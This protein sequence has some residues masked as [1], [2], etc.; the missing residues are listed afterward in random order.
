MNKSVFSCCFFLLLL[1]SINACWTNK[2][3]VSV[4]IANGSAAAQETINTNSFDVALLEQLVFEGINQVRK[5]KNR[6]QLE[7]NTILYKAAK[8]HNDYM[9]RINK[10]TH[11]QNEK[12]KRDVGERVQF[13]G[14]RF[15]MSGENIQFSGFPVAQRGKQKRILYPTYLEAAEKLVQNWVDS[16]THYKNLIHKEFG[17][18][19]T[20]VAYDPKDGGIYATQ[21]YGTKKTL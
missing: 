10:M 3:G 19:G 11:D 8:D 14:G 18:V 17:L 2:Q 21:V 16:P 12:N 5:K 1:F 15:I 20:A 4:T 7:K 13:Y 6:S 9:L